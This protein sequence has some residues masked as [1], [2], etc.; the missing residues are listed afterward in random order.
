M[1]ASSFNKKPQQNAEA[2]PKFYFTKPILLY[3]KLAYWYCYCL[4]KKNWPQ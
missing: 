2:L 3:R 4:Q 1:L